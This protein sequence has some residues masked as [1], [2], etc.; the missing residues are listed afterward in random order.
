[1]SLASEPGN[2]EVEDSTIRLATTWIF[3]DRF[4]IDRFF[5]EE[6]FTERDFLARFYPNISLS[7]LAHSSGFYKPRFY[8]LFVTASLFVMVAIVN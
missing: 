6:F 5:T 2:S 3:I 4:F 8:R 7:D 1:M